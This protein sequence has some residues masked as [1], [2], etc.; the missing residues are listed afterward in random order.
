[1]ADTVVLPVNPDGG[2][3]QAFLFPFG[4]ATYGFVWYVDIAESQLPSARAAD[5]TTL[6]DLSGDGAGGPE[7]GRGAPRGILVV[8]VDR[9]DPDA[10]TPLLRRRVIPGS[11]Y[12]AG[13][14]LL[15]VRSAAIALGNLNAA[16]AFGSAVEVE[17]SAA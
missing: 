4:A 6:I 1:M 9:R 14:L 7:R 2:F 5:P 8:V 10:V 15:Q 17:V 16:G 13:Q 11:S 3:P 12:P